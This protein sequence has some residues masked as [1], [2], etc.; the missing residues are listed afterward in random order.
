VS[1]PP[2]L[3]PALLVGVTLPALLHVAILYIPALRGM[4]SLHPL[5]KREWKVVLAF[6]API[7]IVEEVLK[8]V[9][10]RRERKRETKIY[11]Q[12]TEIVEC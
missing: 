1:C 2:W 5:S 6:A 12:E 4:F 10:R 8:Y 11:S 9:G 3:N 7:I